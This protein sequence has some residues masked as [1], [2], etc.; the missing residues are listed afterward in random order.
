MN[1]IRSTRTILTRFS[2]DFQLNHYRFSISWTRILPDGTLG[3]V[4]QAGIAYYNKL[5]DALLEENIIPVVTI[6]H[7]DVPQTLHYLG[8]FTNEVIVAYFEAYADLVF[9]LFGDRV[10]WWITI[11]EPNIF[12]NRQYTSMAPT[13]RAVDGYGQYLCGHN[14]LKAHTVAYRL[15]Q[16]KYAAY[17]KGQVGI[18][19]DQRF[20][21]SDTNNAADV[22][23]ALEFEVHN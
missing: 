20:F 14:V 4:N 8:G 1:P 18:T 7:F 6:F 2:L 19:L 3:S 16:R 15:Y 13:V 12:C 5:I 11:N 21:Y 17:Y 10:K 9:S 22:K 23:R